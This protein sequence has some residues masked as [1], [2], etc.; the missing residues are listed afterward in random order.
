MRIAYLDLRQELNVL[1]A[2]GDALA[3]V[4]LNYYSEEKN[5]ESEW[6]DPFY[7]VRFE[8]VERT[9]VGYYVVGSSN[10]VDLTAATAAFNS[11]ANAAEMD[12]LESIIL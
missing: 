7:K 2:R 10:I 1:G 9:G 5:D 11:L 8:T 4:E 6:E 3:V 12:L